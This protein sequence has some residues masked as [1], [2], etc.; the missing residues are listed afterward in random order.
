MTSLPGESREPHED[1]LVAE[2]AAVM[3]QKLESDYA[4][5]STKR[6]AHPKHSGLLEGHFT[7][8]AGLPPEL[9]VGVFAQPRRYQAWIRT[10]SASGTIQSDAV[11]DVRGFAIKLLDVP[12]EKVP[13]SDEPATQDF[14]LLSMSHMPLGTVRLFRDAIV[15][16]TRWSPLLF[17][18]K[19]LLTGRRR[20][21][22][23]LKAA[24]IRPT[25]PLDIRYWSTTPYRFGPDRVVKYSLLPHPHLPAP[26][27][28]PL[29]EAYLSEAMEE[30]LSKTSFSFDFAVQFQQT[31]MPVENAAV[32]WP[33]S[34]AAFVKLATLTI[35]PQRFRTPER[36]RLSETLAFS[37]GHALVEHRPVGGINRARMHVYRANSKFRR[38]RAGLTP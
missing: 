19:M 27:P 15:L 36:D 18:A 13:E 37:P 7:V 31:D 9:Q 32:P 2:I 17:V 23:A 24:K 30:Q 6:D 8:E 29:G 16:S 14:V 38:E 26:T 28:S 5:A 1:A 20:M 22:E 21:L 25:S 34:T 3:R 12:G 10:S 4:P 11:P 35:P 33:E